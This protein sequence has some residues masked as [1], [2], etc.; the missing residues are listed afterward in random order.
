MLPAALGGVAL[1]TSGGLL[2]MLGL[3]GKAGGDR[4]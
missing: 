3:R 1:L 4:T 2:R